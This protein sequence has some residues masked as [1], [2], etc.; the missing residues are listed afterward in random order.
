MDREELLDRLRGYEWD[1][2]EVKAAQGGLPEDA[3]KTVSAFANSSGGWLV[4][5][6][7]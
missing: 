1:D 5:G 2:F 3:Y 7:A 4:F 6:V